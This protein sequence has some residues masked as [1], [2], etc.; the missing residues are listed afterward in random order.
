MSNIPG[1]IENIKKLINNHK[2][3]E[4]LDN[5]EEIEQSKDLKNFEIIEILIL[6]LKPL[7]ETS[8]YEKSLQ[9][10]YQILDESKKIGDNISELEGYIGIIES[11]NPLGR[12][13]ESFEVMK[14]GHEIF[15]KL[16]VCGDET[17]KRK[18][19]FL[20]ISGLTY[21]YINK[22]DE[23][24]ANFKES[25]KIRYQ[26][27]EKMGI[28]YCL[29]HIGHVNQNRRSYDIAIKYYKQCLVYSEQFS[30]NM[31]SAWAYSHIAF[32]NYH[33]DAFEEVFINVKRS[34]EISRE[35]K[36]MHSEDFSLTVLGYY[37][38]GKGN[39]S[40]SLDCFNRCL[41]LRKKRGNN[42]EVGY[43]LESIGSVYSARGEL[44]LA[45]LYAKKIFEIPEAINDVVAAPVFYKMIGK[46][47]CE[48]G[49]HEEGKA[50][51]NKS[52]ELYN[53]IKDFISSSRCLHYLISLSLDD[54]NIDSAN[55]YFSSLKKIKDEN[56]DNSQIHQIYQ[57]NNAKILMYYNMADEIKEAETILSIISKDSILDYEI[58]VEAITILIEILLNSIIKSNTLNSIKE[59][60]I[61]LEKML[62]IGKI[63]N[64][65]TIYCE[66]LVYQ[67]KLSLIELKFDQARRFFSEAQKIA[68]EKGLRL[69]SLYISKDH[70]DF[71]LNMNYW[72][73]YC[74]NDEIVNRI[75]HS[76]PIFIF[77]K[78]LRKLP[79]NIEES[80]DKRGFIFIWSGNG[81][82]LFRLKFDESKININDENV[83]KIISIFTLFDQEAILYSSS[84]DRIVYEEYTVIVRGKEHIKFG[85]AFL[86]PSHSAVKKLEL[87]IESVWFLKDIWNELVKE[88]LMNEKINGINIQYL[89]KIAL[90]T[91]Q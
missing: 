13:S 68:Q 65:Y 25:L 14:K 88:N 21:Q 10:S 12:Y 42:V 45:Q 54:N 46:L 80:N 82:E 72:E 26:V 15:D 62:E 38:F 36:N 79:L 4:A 75:E 66:A 64:N 34:L 61:L 30:L 71:L 18:G 51:L 19:H 85:Y 1:K 7:I 48:T 9:I 81:Y 24:L 40:M 23:A 59:I 11:L 49:N 37:H 20:F 22:L 57:I 76:S 41:E 69:L 39:Y 2:Y 63:K 53:N 58:T 16:N 27:D 35:L 84:V 89:E 17:L 6:K 90:K 78:I 3:S 43:V 67:A 44:L 74:K 8:S 87:F 47:Y 91:F 32:A 86:G 28:A 33:L 31:C 52:I 60:N 50:K 70:D 5:I 77:S 56:L 83:K 29:L 73:K 55:N